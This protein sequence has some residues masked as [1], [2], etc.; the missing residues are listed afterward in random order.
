MTSSRGFVHCCIFC[1]GPVLA[2]R[3]EEQD[4]AAFDELL[5][6]CPECGLYQI[7]DELARRL[8]IDPARRRAAAQ[9]VR[10]AAAEGVLP[11]L[12]IQREDFQEIMSPFV[13]ALQKCP[14]CRKEAPKRAEGGVFVHRDE[15]K[16][17]CLAAREWAMASE[18]P[19]F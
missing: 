12:C 17:P 10:E 9:F 1:D 18:S 4:R 6:S 5:Y 2:L 8:S 7:C 13:R 11:R 3:R 16:S 15:G 19:G 14:K